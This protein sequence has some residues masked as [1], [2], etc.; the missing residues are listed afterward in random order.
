M[1]D[2][3]LTLGAWGNADEPPGSLSAGSEEERLS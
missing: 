2:S 1:R 3:V